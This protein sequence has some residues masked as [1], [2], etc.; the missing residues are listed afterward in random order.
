MTR[1]FDFLRSME[2]SSCILLLWPFDKSTFVSDLKGSGLLITRKTD[3]PLTACTI[4]KSKWPQTT[5]DDKVVLRVF[6]SK[7]SNDVV[8]QYSDEE[9]TELAVEEIQHIMRFSALR[10]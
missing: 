4:P 6:I 9:L 10:T 5:P 2:Q 3:T 1:V 7:P 8:E